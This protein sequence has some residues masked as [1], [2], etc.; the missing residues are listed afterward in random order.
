MGNELDSSGPAW[1][2]GMEGSVSKDFFLNWSCAAIQVGDQ[3]W[4][5]ILNLSSPQEELTRWTEEGL[6][7]PMVPPLQIWWEPGAGPVWV[8]QVG[9]VSGQLLAFLDSPEAERR[10]RV[11]DNLTLLVFFDREFKAYQEDVFNHLEGEIQRLGSG[12]DRYLRDLWR[13]GITLNPNHPVTDKLRIFRSKTPKFN[14]G[15]S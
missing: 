11:S 9:S 13:V 5:P 3:I 14:Q 7:T 2:V 15:G 10:W 12:S 8:V 1:V 4:N 6:V